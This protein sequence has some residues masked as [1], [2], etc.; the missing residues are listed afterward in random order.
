MSRRSM[1]GNLDASSGGRRSTLVQTASAERMIGVQPASR[2]SKKVSSAKSSIPV[3]KSHADKKRTVTHGFTPK[4]TAKFPR[5]LLGPEHHPEALMSPDGVNLLNESGVS[6][7][8]GDGTDEH[9]YLTPHT[10]RSDGALPRAM[11]GITSSHSRDDDGVVEEGMRALHVS[12]DYAHV[13]V[14]PESIS[15][16]IS[17]D[18]PIATSTPPVTSASKLTPRNSTRKSA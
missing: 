8:P 12:G 16:T 5:T 11:A 15:N 4:T 1:D 17:V 10:S 14:T 13:P 2:V 6:T 18:G 7:G 3:L 9:E